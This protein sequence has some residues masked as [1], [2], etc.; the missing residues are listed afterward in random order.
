MFGKNRQNNKGSATGDLIYADT[1]PIR[2]KKDADPARWHRLAAAVI[3]LTAVLTALSIAFTLWLSVQ[4]RE[5]RYLH[6]RSLLSSREYDAAQ[7]EFEALGD[8][9][10][11]QSQ[12][13]ALEGLRQAYRAAEALLD[14]QRYDEA[15][16]A[17]RALGDYADSSRQAAYGVTY[18]KAMD[19]LS[20]TDE[21]RTQ[22]LLRILGS[23]ARL[24]DDNDYPAVVGYEAAA[25]LF[26]S[27]GDYENAP[28][29]ADRCYHSAARVRM[30]WEDWEGALAYMD[31]MSQ[32]AAD[33]LYQEYLQAAAETE[34]G[35]GQ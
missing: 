18:R 4:R 1:Q 20:Q 29:L 26:E 16:S 19:L 17:F 22:L 25:A 35:E 24:T 34:D 31:R 11:S 33:D 9:R 32:S 12:Y 5:E 15:V 7:A 8:Y 6:A 13:G 21:G 27:L 14:Q 2:S 30:K 23:Q 3:T 28:V 10:D